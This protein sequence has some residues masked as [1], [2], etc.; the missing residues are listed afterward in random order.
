MEVPQ[1][2]AAARTTP[3]ADCRRQTADRAHRHGAIAVAGQ[4]APQAD[5]GGT[6]SCIIMGYPFYGAGGQSTHSCHLLWRT[7]GQHGGGKCIETGDIICNEARIG[8]TVSHHDVQHRQRQS[9]VATRRDNKGFIDGLAGGGA[10][11]VNRPDTGAA[12]PC[13]LGITHGVDAGSG[14]VDTPQD[15]QVA[16]CDLVRLHGRG[17]AHDRLP[18]G[19][20]GRGADGALQSRS[21]Q[22]VKKGVA[23]VALHQPH[24]AG[25][26]IGQDAFGTI[27]C[28]Q[29]IPAGA[30]R[31]DRRIPG[32]RLELPGAFRPDPPQRCRQ[33]TGG[34]DGLLVVA[35]LGA[36]QA[37]RDR[38]IRVA[39]DLDG[40]APLNSYQQA[41]GVG[42]VVGADGTEGG[43]R[44][45]RVPFS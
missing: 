36:E 42:A 16:L 1:K 4:A 34:V 11:G 9:A 18:A 29:L 26:G 32:Y 33:P 40:P 30:D 31:L 38:M 5:K 20:L 12:P 23:A 37:A 22:L 44:H 13:R 43:G 6:G 25:I 45:D 17:S 10:I 8:Q 21:A 39:R 35:H 7:T 2:D 24:R 14:G 3:G 28:D 19:I 41:A 27:L 15:D